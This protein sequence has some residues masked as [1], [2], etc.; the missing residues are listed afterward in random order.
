MTAPRTG[1]DAASKENAMV[2][3]RKLLVLIV[4]IWPFTVKLTLYR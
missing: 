4:V 2:K 3:H 1:R